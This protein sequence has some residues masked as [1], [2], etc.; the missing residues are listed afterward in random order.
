MACTSIKICATTM[1]ASRRISAQTTTC[2]VGLPLSS[3]RA[4]RPRHLADEFKNI[5]KHW[6]TTMRKLPIN[7]NFVAAIYQTSSSDEESI[8]S[9][10]AF[11]TIGIA[12]AIHHTLAALYQRWRAVTST[13]FTSDLAISL[14]HK[15][16]KQRVLGGASIMRL[17]H[18]YRRTSFIN[19]IATNS[20]QRARRGEQSILVRLCPTAEQQKR[21]RK[22]CAFARK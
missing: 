21:Q 4:V 2:S 19:Q 20:P 7:C 22:K 5:H 14:N 18:A 1:P 8:N 17:G 10:V 12:G 15:A 16:E 13:L 9:T 3:T 11:S 6:R